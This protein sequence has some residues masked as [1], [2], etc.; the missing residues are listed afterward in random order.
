MRSFCPCL[1]SVKKLRLD[2]QEHNC[3]SGQVYTN[4]NT[5]VVPFGLTLASYSSSYLKNFNRS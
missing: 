5:M 2:N 1:R 3:Q 4:P